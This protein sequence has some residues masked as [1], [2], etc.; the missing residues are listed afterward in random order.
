[1]LRGK[2]LSLICSTDANPLNS[3]TYHFYFNDG[4]IGN[5]SSGVFNVTVEA[6][7][8][9][10]CVPSNTVGTGRNATVSV[11]DAGKSVIKSI[12]V[13]SM[14]FCSSLHGACMVE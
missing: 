10:T 14:D 2:T 12:H 1:M 11:T 13:F 7:G 5:S 6:D 4:Y 8:V 9:Y 3:V